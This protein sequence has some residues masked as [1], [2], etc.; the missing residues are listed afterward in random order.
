MEVEIPESTKSLQAFRDDLREPKVTF[1]RC[2]ITGEWGKVSAI[3]L[4]DIS[5]DMPDIEN[6]VQYDAE[7][8][9]VAFTKA[10]PVVFHNQALFSRGG[11]EKLMAYMDSQD[12]PIPAVTPELAYKWQVNYTD[13]SALSQF[14]VNPGTDEFEEVNSAEIDHARV[15]Q[16]S[17]VANFPAVERSEGLPTFTFV[18]ES[19]KFYK[20]GEEIDTMFDHDYRPDSEVIYARKV[21][22]TFGSSMQ[23]GSLDRN[24]MSAH[25]SVLQLMGWK[26]GG[27]HGEGP[28]CIIAVDDR[29]H[30]RPYE[31]IED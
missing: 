3:D 7:S 16:L 17:I 27:L 2:C 31:Y 25:I 21:N 5:I 9:A 8:K 19:G 4:G 1:G 29:G 24:I 12:N 20:N 14:Q 28:G 18:K 6:G 13:G 26:V 30:W 11:L 15:G 22:A 10:K 23:V